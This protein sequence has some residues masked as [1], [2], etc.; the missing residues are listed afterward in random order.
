MVSCFKSRDSV[1]WDK[2]S[3]HQLHDDNVNILKTS[4]LYFKMVNMA[5]THTHI[6]IR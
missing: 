6:N 2:S 4:K 5:N 3:G 1:L